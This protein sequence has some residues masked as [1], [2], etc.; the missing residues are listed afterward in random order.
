[1]KIPKISLGSSARKRY[2]RSMSNDSQTTM[3]F[4]FVEPIFTQRLEAKGSVSCSYRQLVRLAPMPLPTFGRVS[5]RNEIAFC[6]I[7][8]VVPYYDAMI[9]RK[10][11]YGGYANYTPTELPYT[12][13]Q[14]LIYN[15]LCNFSEWSVYRQQSNGKYNISTSEASAAQSEFYQI[16]FS[17]APPTGVTGNLLLNISNFVWQKGDDSLGPVTF[18]GADYIFASYTSKAYFCF[19]LSNTGRR[20]RKIL[21][22]LGYSLNAEDGD[23]LSIAPILGYYKSWFDRYEVKRTISWLHTHCFHLIKEIESDYRVDWTQSL[24]KDNSTIDKYAKVWYLFFSEELANTWYVSPDDYLSVQRANPDNTGSVDPYPELSY[25]DNL[26]VNAEDDK[27]TL[28]QPSISIP[29]SGRYSLSNVS[30]QILQ[31]YTRWINK[32]SVIGQKLSDFLR[33]HFGAEISNSVYR[34]V[35]RIGSSNVPVDISDVF[36]TSDTASE[37]SEGVRTGEYLGSYAGKG[38]G[39]SKYGFKFT[40]PSVGYV[41]VFSCIVPDSG[42]FQGNAFDLY[43]LDNDTIPNPDYD[44]VGYEVTPRGSLVGSNDCFTFFSSLTNKGFGFVPRYSMFKYKKNIVNG[45]LSRRGSIDSFSPYY[46]DRILIQR[47][48]TATGKVGEDIDVKVVNADVPNASESWRY[49]CRYDWLGNFNRMFYEDTGYT[50]TSEDKKLVDDH[51][52]VQTLFD[53]KVTDFLKPLSQSYDTFE[54]SSDTS[55]VDVKMD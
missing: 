52:I 43:A 17:A 20:L 25:Y 46:L 44:A 28:T 31:R 14:F 39:Y 33:V 2:T 24:Y 42:T 32:N 27:K 4:G 29:G 45:D 51:F 48:I 36:S 10:S 26:A 35:Y 13:N 54:E 15:I 23:H 55:T 38:I 53:V 34:D 22:G 3:D 9:A 16:V 41:F 37:S 6:P 49:P 11:Y 8:D 7:G 50:V 21:I 1:M 12:T 19:R 18:D 47:Q 5:L 40:A 30:L